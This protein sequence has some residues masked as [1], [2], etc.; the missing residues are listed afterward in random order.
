M[1]PQA[2][3]SPDSGCDYMSA[4]VFSDL[5]TLVDR[6]HTFLNEIADAPWLSLPHRTLAQAHLV[7]HEWLANLVQYADFG[8]KAPSVSLRIQ[9]ERG[10][11]RFMI[12]DN[13]TGFDFHARMQVQKKTLRA[14]PNRGLGLLM[15]AACTEELSYLRIGPSHHRLIFAIPT[16]HNP[17]LDIPLR[18]EAA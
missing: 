8:D 14:L 5:D 12:D 18:E 6:G 13:S 7:T 17:A 16:D 4:R 2:M 11:T 1:Y 9:V 15:I 3:Y 10:R